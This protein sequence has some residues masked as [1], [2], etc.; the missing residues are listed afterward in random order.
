MVDIGVPKESR[1]FE[2]RVGLTPPN[3]AQLTKMGNRVY[4]EKDA[5]S[6]A[7]FSNLDY[8][9]AGAIIVYD[10]E[11]IFMR[12]DVLIKVSRPTYEEIELMKD[13]L[14]LLGFMHLHA[15]K[16]DKIEL[17]SKKKITVIAYELLSDGE[18]F[19]I[20]KAI[21]TLA[22]KMIPSIASQLLTNLHGGSGILLSGAP[23]IPPAEIV[24]IGA[25]QA[26]TTIAREFLNIGAQV[27][28]LDKNIKKLEKISQVLG[29]R[30]I[31]LINV[32]S[33]LAKVTAF[34]DV[35]VSC[36]AIAGNKA[37]IIFD[38]DLIV[39]MKER[40]VFIDIA[41]DQ[42]GNSTTSRPTNHGSPTYVKYNIIHYCVPNI[43]SV[44]ARSS[45]RALNIQLKHCLQD[46]LEPTKE[47][48]DTLKSNS[49]WRSGVVLNKGTATHPS[50]KER[51]EKSISST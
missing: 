24:I 10:R 45:S 26:G 7:G 17:L 13:G 12:P 19:P 1:P 23:G 42:G 49:F 38:D 36:A 15:S 2:Y 16:R 41:I 22:G 9:Q 37:P 46:L 50:I 34:A 4:I 31:T 27:T 21:S 28:V 3:V 44:I 39:S 47:I 33:N 29:N 8:E 35:L 11:E 25:G 40:S 14:V 43:S 32:P 48:H 20:L 5:G 6:F 18:T 51:L 30:L